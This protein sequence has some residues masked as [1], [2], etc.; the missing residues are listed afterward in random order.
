MRVGI[1]NNSTN[2]YQQNKGLTFQAKDVPFR[3]VRSKMQPKFKPESLAGKLL[4]T[5]EDLIFFKRCTI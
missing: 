2:L 3:F 5:I 1:V 4:K